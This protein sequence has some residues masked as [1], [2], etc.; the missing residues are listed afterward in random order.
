MYGQIFILDGLKLHNPFQAVLDGWFRR[1]RKS[2]S[3]LVSSSCSIIKAAAQPGFTSAYGL[4]Q[5]KL[6]ES[7]ELV[8]PGTSGA[9]Y[10][11]ICLC[12]R[13]IST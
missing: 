12:G 10:W 4:Q 6:K 5:K 11:Q 13:A 9:F 1:E 3:G 8:I 2:T 7:R